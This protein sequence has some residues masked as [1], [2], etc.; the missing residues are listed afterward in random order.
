MLKLALALIMLSLAP[1]IC[2]AI[3]K[4]KLFLGAKI[5]ISNTNAN[6]SAPDK[7]MNRRTNILCS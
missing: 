7:P 3:Q 1:K 2:T 6:F 5:S 4:A